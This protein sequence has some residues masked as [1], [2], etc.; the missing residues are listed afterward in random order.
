MLRARWEIYQVLRVEEGRF[1]EEGRVEVD[2]E[3]PEGRNGDEG[4]SLGSLLGEDVD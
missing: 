3:E 1:E 4:V 2:A